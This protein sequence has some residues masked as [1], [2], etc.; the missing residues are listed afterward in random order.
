MHGIAMECFDWVSLK[1]WFQQL[2]SETGTSDQI[3]YDTFLR[4]LYECMVVN[5]KNQYFLDRYDIIIN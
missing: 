5:D 1:Y 3:F 2:T 4:M